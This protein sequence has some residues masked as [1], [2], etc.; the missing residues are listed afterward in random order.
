MA[1]HGGHAGDGSMRPLKQG[2]KESGEG[3]LCSWSTLFL[4]HAPE[5]AHGLLQGLQKSSEALLVKQVTARGRDRILPKS[6]EQLSRGTLPTNAAEAAKH[7]ECTIPGK[8][9]KEV[10]SPITSRSS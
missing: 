7:D 6:D 5:L 2:E 4:T 1:V 9:R 10:S 3:F 8:Q